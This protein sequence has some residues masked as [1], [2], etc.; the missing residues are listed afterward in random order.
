MAAEAAALRADNVALVEELEAAQA[1]LRALGAEHEAAVV[2]A[3]A[4]AACAEAE[5][6]RARDAAAHMMQLADQIQSMF[7]MCEVSRLG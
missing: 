5:V 7:A 1:A 4:G 3:E 2:A 6:S